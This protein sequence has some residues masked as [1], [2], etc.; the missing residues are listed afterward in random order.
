MKVTWGPCAADDTVKSSWAGMGQFICLKAG[1]CS[2]GGPSGC[3]GGLL[4]KEAAKCKPREDLIAGS[5]VEQGAETALEAGKCPGPGG[6][7]GQAA[8]SSTAS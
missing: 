5:S 1:T 6:Q 3:G 7:E 8:G 2:T 4:G